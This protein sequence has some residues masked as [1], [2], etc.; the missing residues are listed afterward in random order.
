MTAPPS[1]P[2][3]HRRAWWA[4][5]LLSGIWGYNWVVMKLAVRDASPVAFSGL[6][7][8]LGALSLFAVLAWRRV[9]LAP[10]RLPQVAVL[11]LLQTTA[12]AGLTVWA[13]TLGGAGRTAVLVYTMPFWTLAFAWWFLGERIRGAQWLVVALALVGL[14]LLVEPWGM[15]GELPGKLLA[16]GAGV[17]WALS[18]VVAKRLAIRTGD[19]L[20]S[21]TAWQLLLGSV[22]LLAVAPLVS[23]RPIH[24]TPGFMV[25]LAYNAVPANALAWLLWLYILSK[26]PAGLASLSMLATPVVGVFSAWVQL[27]ERPNLGEALGMTS[28]A[29]A[30]VLLTW[31]RA[32]RA[33]G[34]VR[35]GALKGG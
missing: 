34:P 14:V 27:G 5:A 19:E 15:Q 1:P 18:S 32:A 24:W 10:G 4:L 35:G 29:L 22:P 21:V 17:V 9:P 3:T 7:S 20:L 33:A 16:V 11:G 2:S 6:R 8:F 31:L 13:V 23:A 26:L 25:A 30:L 12:F 28:V